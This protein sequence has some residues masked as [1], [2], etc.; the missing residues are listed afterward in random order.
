MADE[1]EIQAECTAAY[2][3]FDRIQREGTDFEAEAACLRGFRAVVNLAYR[4]NVRVRPGG[5]PHA[6]EQIAD[7]GVRFRTDLGAVRFMRVTHRHV[8]SEVVNALITWRLDDLPTRA[9][10]TE[11]LGVEVPQAEY[12]TITRNINEPGAT[13]MLWTSA[14]VGRNMTITPQQ[15]PAA[16]AINFIEEIANELSVA[17]KAQ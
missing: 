4:S 13:T 1:D 17:H 2:A 15:I 8:D 5:D 6:A 10:L 14:L 7:P 11:Y 16:V 9:D 12:D 3:D